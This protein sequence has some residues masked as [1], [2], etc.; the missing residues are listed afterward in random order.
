M[1]N[2]KILSVGGDGRSKNR[3]KRSASPTL[4]VVFPREMLDRIEEQ[5]WRARISK[6]E[7]VRRL[8][9]KGLK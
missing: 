3:K 7:F 5:A 9:E 4:S 6:G 8:V 2:D 1:K